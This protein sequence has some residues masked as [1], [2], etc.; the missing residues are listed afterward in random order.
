M[1][2]KFCKRP[3]KEERGTG[4]KH[5]NRRTW[6]GLGEAV[7]AECYEEGLPGRDASWDIPFKCGTH[8]EFGS[9][10]A[11]VT[12][13]WAQCHILGANGIQDRL[14]LPC[15]WNGEQYSAV[16][17]AGRSPNG[18]IRGRPILQRVRDVNCA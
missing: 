18:G 15:P 5:S 12:G 2:W 3:R 13:A 14:F 9:Q 7:R 1:Q 10:V 8:R 11:Q 4:P 6:N 17:V 16:L